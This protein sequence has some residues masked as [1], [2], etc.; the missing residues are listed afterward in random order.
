MFPLVV[1]II[2]PNNALSITL[3]Y[4][5]IQ[6][7]STSTSLLIIFL[8]GTHLTMQ[9]STWLVFSIALAIRLVCAK[10]SIIPDADE[11]FNYWEPLHF[12]SHGFGLQTWEYSPEYAIRSW[13][14]IMLHAIPVKAS[15][16]LL[17]AEGSVLFFVLRGCFATVAAATETRLYVALSHAFSKRIAT[18]YLMFSLASTGLFHASV[19]F[20]PSSFAMHAFTLALAEF[21]QS[22]TYRNKHNSIIKGILWTAVS[23]LFGWP[24][25]LIL[26]VPFAIDYFL[27]TI[28]SDIKQLMQSIVKVLLATVLL[29]L[30]PLFLIDS[31]AYRKFVLVP[32]NIV[33]YNVI[34]STDDAGPNI[35]GTEPWYYYVFNLSLNFNLAF[36]LAAV[37]ILPAGF[38]SPNRRGLLLA[39]SPFYLW[40]GIFIVQPHKEERFMYVIYQSLCLNAAVSLEFLFQLSRKFTS[41][42]R[43]SKAFTGGCLI[44]YTLI[45]LSRTC[46]LINYYSAPIKVFEAFSEDASSGNVCVGREW[47]RYPSS[48]FLNNNQRLKFVK[49]A[50]DGLLPGEFYEPDGVA[51]Q[52]EWWNRDATWLIPEGM[53]NQNIEDPSK[54]IDISQCDYVVDTSIPAGPGEDQYTALT[55]QWER[56]HCEPFLDNENSYGI[57]RILML[58]IQLHDT[59]RT[60]LRWADYCILGRNRHV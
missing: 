55:E 5:L 10:Y 25:S 32:P 1:Y 30:L 27:S 33:L 41:N 29:I 37:S 20:L 12:L 46:A 57:G 23:G 49:S 47:Y 31:I 11:V 22:G 60:R 16:L 56:I 36:L 40:L 21:V 17:G 28:T 14:Y 9:I 8:K 44:L 50:F 35:F 6:T 3:R 59:L 42:T 4:K 24:F 51:D 52:R 19:E 2:I 43:L 39:V 34:N 38:V 13:A 53:N 15:Q 45:S 26:M 58:P 18:F 54:Y 7:R 48:Y